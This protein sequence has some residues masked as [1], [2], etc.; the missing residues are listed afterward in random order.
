MRRMIAPLAVSINTVMKI[1]RRAQVH[2]PPPLHSDSLSNIDIE[3]TK[4]SSITDFFYDDP[5]MPYVALP[6]HKLDQ[7]PCRHITAIN[8]GYYY[9]RLHPST[10]DGHLEWI[11]EY[12]KYKEPEAYKLELL[13]LNSLIGT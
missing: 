9:C 4:V 5:T 10:K 1:T 2:V 8:D 6:D 11:E 12:I 7:S 13:K 3:L